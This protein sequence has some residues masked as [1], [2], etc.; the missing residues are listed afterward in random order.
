VLDAPVES[1]FAFHASDGALKALLPPNGRVVRREGG[2][3][4][5]SRVELEFRLGP[6]RLRWVARHTEYRKNELFADVQERGPFRRWAHRHEFAA[7]GSG[8]CRLTDAVEF[9]LPGGAMVDF[10]GAWA[11]KVALRGMFRA[12]HRAT[13]AALRRT[14]RPDSRT[15]CTGGETRG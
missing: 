7:E 13:S 14:L 12:R 2:L 6:L 15:S 8:R 5:G 11:A 9:S 4:A 1:V 10:V 3:E